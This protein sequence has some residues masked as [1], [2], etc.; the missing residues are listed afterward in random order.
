MTE[1][2]NID[3]LPLNSNSNGTYDFLNGSFRRRISKKL[4]SKNWKCR[5]DGLEELNKLIL[6]LENFDYEIFI[7]LPKILIDQHQGNLEYALDIINVF[8]DKKFFIP[9]DN[10]NILNDIIKNL[11]E[12][13]F[14]SSK[15]NI[16]EKSK[17]AIIKGVENLSNTDIL[18]ENIIYLILKIQKLI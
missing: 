2:K 12:K 16:K 14:S 7:L 8:F 18:C 11:I 1:I 9:R 13:C 4:E 3:E 5:K 17:E 10:V 6:K 15:N